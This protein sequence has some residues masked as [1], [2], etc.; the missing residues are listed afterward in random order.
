MKL[1]RQSKLH[2]RQGKSDKVYEV[3]LC[4]AGGGEFL[5][6]FRYGRRGTDLREGTKTPFPTSR[7]KAEGIFDSLVA[8]KTHKGYRIVGGSGI[9][10]AQ[11]AAMS[12]EVPARY[13][14]RR[15]A[16]VKRLAD[17]AGRRGPPK[18]GWRL[19]RVIWRAGAWRMG[20]AAG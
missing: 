8:E 18:A 7:A 10:A 13:D 6:N 1:V 20:E 11:P 9:A 14:P 19:S 12:V 5:V 15:Y 4:E 3:D 16:V 2:F 17:E